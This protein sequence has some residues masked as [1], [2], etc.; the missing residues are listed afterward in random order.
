MADLPA[1]LSHLPYDQLQFTLV[2]CPGHASLIRTVLGGAQI[3]DI[4]MLA[5]RVARPATR[6]IVSNPV[7]YLYT[8]MSHSGHQPRTA[9]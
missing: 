6:K 3:I 5:G 2:D 1:S 8:T 4:M 9:S 7:K